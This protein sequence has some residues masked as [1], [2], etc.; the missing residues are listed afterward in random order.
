MQILP[1]IQEHARIHLHHRCQHTR[2]DAIAE[3][4]ALCWAWFLRQTQRGKDP[5][6]FVSALATF[7]VKHV[8]SGRKLAGNKSHK[9]VLAPEVQRRYGFSVNRMPQHITQH[10]NVLEE[11]L[12]DNI[13][14]PIPDQVHYRTLLPPWLSSL[15][16]RRRAIAEN[17]MLGERTREVAARHRLSQ[18]RISQLRSELKKDWQRFSGE[19]VAV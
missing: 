2:A 18:G 16:Q 11:A 3:A 12:H 4:V 10:T 19:L 17:L 14:T 6:T 13:I 7:A 5:T 15:G 8:R 9:D 1:R